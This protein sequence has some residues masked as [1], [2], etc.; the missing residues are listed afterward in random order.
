MG[1]GRRERYV[2]AD[3]SKG[4][5]GRNGGSVRAISPGEDV[6]ETPRSYLGF[7]LFARGMRHYAGGVSCKFLSIDRY[8]SVNSD[9]NVGALLRA[10]VIIVVDQ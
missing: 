8:P 9:L 7:G 4:G 3:E 2:P 10:V 6:R 5:I 1:R